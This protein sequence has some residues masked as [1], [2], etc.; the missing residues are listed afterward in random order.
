[1]KNT[2]EHSDEQVFLTGRQV[3]NDDGRFLLP[4]PAI[5]DA[6]EVDKMRGEAV[7]ARAFVAR[8][9]LIS[10]KQEESPRRRSL[11]T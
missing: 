7:G 4:D 11:H 6:L 8:R 5:V 3:A 2:V 9:N 1:M 10:A